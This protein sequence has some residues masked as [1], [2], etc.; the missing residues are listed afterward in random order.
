MFHNHATP[1]GI[2]ITTNK[3]RLNKLSQANTHT[4][5]VKLLSSQQ[6]GFG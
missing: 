2:Y 3:L 1:H 6:G 4:S 5:G